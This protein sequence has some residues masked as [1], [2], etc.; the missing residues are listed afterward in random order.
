MKHGPYGTEQ[1]EEDNVT[2][3]QV[4]W[5]QENKEPKVSGSRDGDYEDCLRGVISCNMADC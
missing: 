5:K 2:K 4:P 3:T 1:K